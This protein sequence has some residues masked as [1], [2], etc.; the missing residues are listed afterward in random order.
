MS[1]ILTHFGFLGAALLWEHDLSQSNSAAFSPC[2][3]YRY[4]LTR[5]LAGSGPWLTFVMLNPSRATATEP[6]R[7]VGRCMYFAQRGG[8]A[9]LLVANLFAFRATFPSD[10][11][12]QDD[13]VGPLNDYVLE[14]LPKGP[15]VAGWGDQPDPRVAAR[16]ARVL[17]ILRAENQVFCLGKTQSGAPRHPSRLGNNVQLEA[18]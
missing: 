15:I 12:A 7:T 9:G 8:H 4:L 13:P 10:C 18:L 5:T 11:F 1:A 2:K 6:D 17:E 14:R 3:K 16:A